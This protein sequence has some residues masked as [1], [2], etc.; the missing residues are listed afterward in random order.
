MTSRPLSHQPLP[1]HAKKVFSGVLFD[2]YHWDQEMFDGTT[3]VFEKLTRA[4]VVSVLPILDN[5]NILLC[6]QEQPSMS[7]FMSLIGGMVNPEEDTQAA[8]LRELREESGY[9]CRELV[10]WYAEHSF[11]SKIDSVSTVYFG[12]GCAQTTQQHLDAGEKISLMEVS[13]EELVQELVYDPQF[14]NADIALHILREYTHPQT[15]QAFTDR[16]RPQ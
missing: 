11:G 15:R 14:R 12:Y 7:P 5:G 9:T 13:F 10:P 6:H 4:D 8:A 16:F 2:V 1:A 3:E